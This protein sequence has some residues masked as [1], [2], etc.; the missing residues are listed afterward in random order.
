MASSMRCHRADL[1]GPPIEPRLCA[2]SHQ[3]IADDGLVDDPDDGPALLDQRNERAEEIGAT[4]EGLGAVDGIQHP[5]VGRAGLVFAVLLAQD[6]VVGVA[7]G[8]QITHDLFRLAVGHGDRRSVGLQLDLVAGTIVV[9]DHA[10]AGFG[11]EAGEVQKLLLFLS[12]PTHHYSVASSKNS[13]NW[14]CVASS[15]KSVQNCHQLAASRRPSKRLRRR[16]T[17]S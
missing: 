16:H 14:A 11:Q 1:D 4:H 2:G 17:A 3:E 12:R 9:A 8:D 13:F 6:A 10:A 7:P 15:S 5:L